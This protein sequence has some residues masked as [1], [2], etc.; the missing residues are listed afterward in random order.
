MSI[1]LFKRSYTVRRYGKQTIKNGYAA[2]P[3]DDITVML[4]I[5][6]LTSNELRTLPE[7]E[8]TVKRI[9]AF[10]P[11]HL[12]SAD[13]FAGTLGDRLFYNG[14]WYECKS[15]VMWDHTPL[16]HYRSEFVILPKNE[17][18]KPPGDNS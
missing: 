5:Q 16:S 2:S 12:T 17:Q 13:E 4:N 1:G 14:Q 18:M 11:D 8:R 9:K 6:P 3:W 15:S 10:G 7:G